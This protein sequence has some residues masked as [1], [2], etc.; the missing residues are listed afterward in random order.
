LVATRRSTKL[1]T[2]LRLRS[3]ERPQ[4]GDCA[5]AG[6]VEAASEALAAGLKRVQAAKDIEQRRRIVIEDVGKL[7][8]KLDAAMERAAAGRKPHERALLDIVRDKAIGD[9][10]AQICN[11][12]AWEV[13]S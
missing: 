11:A 9:V 1:A 4:Q 5:A 6:D 3:N 8:G 10:V 2:Q 12:C 13:R 7:V